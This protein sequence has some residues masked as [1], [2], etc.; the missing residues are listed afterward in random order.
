MKTRIHNLIIL[1]ESGSMES[2]K[3]AAINGMNETVQ[4]IR[5]AQKKHDDQEHIVS[6]VSFN[7]SE[8][9]GIYD[10]VP[11]AEVKELTDKEYVPDCCTPLYDAMGLSLNHLRAKVNDEDKV[12][13]TIITDGEENSSSE[14]NSAAIKALVD[15]LKEKGWVFAYI[16]ANQDVLKVAQTISVTNVMNFSSTDFGTTSAIA[17]LRK[18]RDRMFSRIADGVFDSVSENTDFFS[19]DEK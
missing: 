11:V 9:K 10:C 15:S 14:Y 17:S 4:S 13:V 3:R 18:S 7:S 2:I 5:D 19:E 16:G 1:D 12:L 6:L 8:I